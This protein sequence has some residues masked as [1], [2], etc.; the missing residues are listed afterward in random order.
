M[1]PKHL[2]VLVLAVVAVGLSLIAF[3][4]PSEALPPAPH[5]PTHLEGALE[6]PAPARPVLL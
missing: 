3:A 6:R 5:V 2:L 1:S 4:R